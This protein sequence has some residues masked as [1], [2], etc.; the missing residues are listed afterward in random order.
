M[1]LNLEL[2]PGSPITEIQLMGMSRTP[3]RQAL[4]RLEQEGFVNLMPRK[5]W[6]VVDILDFPPA[7]LVLA[8]V[9]GPMLEDSFRQSLMMSQGDFSVFFASSMS[10]GLSLL[11]AAVLILPFLRGI[12]K[13]R[14]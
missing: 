14:K 2:H 13:A 6:F 11:A 12:V 4:H 1:L 9:I 7:P 5:G 3:I 8:L 10:K